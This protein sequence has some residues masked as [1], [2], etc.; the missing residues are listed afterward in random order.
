MKVNKWQRALQKN[1]PASLKSLKKYCKEAWAELVKER[2]GYKCVLCGSTAYIN[3]HHIITTKCVLTRYEVDCGIT[4]CS[5]CHNFRITS[6]HVSPWILYEWLRT[7]RPKQYRWFLKHREAVRDEQP[8]LL[9]DDYKRILANLL[10]K[11][12]SN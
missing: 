7:N 3:A 5:G 4:L 10:K 2:D 11:Q 8:K 6:A 12:R 9:T 1:R